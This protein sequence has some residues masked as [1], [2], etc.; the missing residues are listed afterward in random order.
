MPTTLGDLLWFL[1]NTKEEGLAAVGTLSIKGNLSYL[2]SF[3]ES[4]EEEYIDLIATLTIHAEGDMAIKKNEDG[5][6]ESDLYL[7]VSSDDKPYDDEKP[8]G[9]PDDDKPLQDG[10]TIIV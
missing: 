1:E 9:D 7:K 5:A 2:L 8:P 4:I 3:L 6:F 10:D